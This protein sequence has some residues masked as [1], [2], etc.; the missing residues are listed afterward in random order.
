MVSESTADLIRAL[1]ERGAHDDAQALADEA[2]RLSLIHILSI[3]NS[4]SA[5]EEPGLW[6][7]ATA[8]GTPAARSAATGGK[9]VS[10]RK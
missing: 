9:W 5:G 10:R 4:D 3:S 6:S 2:L 1:V 7:L 8:M